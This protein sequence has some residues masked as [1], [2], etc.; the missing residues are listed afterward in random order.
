MTETLV[1]DCCPWL[2]E[3]IN[4]FK[5]LFNNLCE[6]CIYILLL[7]QY[8]KKSLDLE[9]ELTAL[10]LHFLE[11]QDKM[12][13]ISTYMMKKYFLLLHCNQIVYSCK[14]TIFK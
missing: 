13:N 1:S 9:G 10:K 11:I 8:K 4:Y 6:C 3:Y 7:F 5:I 12:V 14:M 2:G